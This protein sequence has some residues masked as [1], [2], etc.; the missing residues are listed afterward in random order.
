MSKGAINLQR[1]AASQDMR[2]ETFLELQN[3]YNQLEGMR[4][5]FTAGACSLSA[6]SSY[7]RWLE[8]YSPAFSRNWTEVDEV[9]I[10]LLHICILMA[11][12]FPS[13]NEK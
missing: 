3:L 2:S 8:K 6:C 9:S 13:I 12:Y 7:A 1:I 10:S 11:T 4:V 5:R